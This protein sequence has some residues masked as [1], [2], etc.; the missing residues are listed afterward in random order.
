MP[1]VLEPMHELAE[2]CVENIVRRV[3]SAAVIALLQSPV[4]SL[5]GA[6]ICY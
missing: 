6:C 4:L 3:S 5:P 1:H 2:A